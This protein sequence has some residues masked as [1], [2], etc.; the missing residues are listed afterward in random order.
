MNRIHGG[1]ACLALVAGIVAGCRQTGDDAPVARPSVEFV[2]GSLDFFPAALQVSPFT[3]YYKE[4]FRRMSEPSMYGARIP[5]GM[6]VIRLLW[7]R[8][9]DP[10]VVI[11]IA[12]TAE[13]CTIGTTIDG[14]GVDE[15]GVPDLQG[16]MPGVAK[17]YGPLLR[18]DSSELDLERCGRVHANAIAARL[19]S[20]SMTDTLFA[21]DGGD[22]VFELADSSGYYVAK[23]TDTQRAPEFW[24]VAARFIE[25]ANVN[26]EQ[27]KNGVW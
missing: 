9:F 23:R 8:S 12:M 6:T 18:R 14:V 20:G 10:V 24:K 15:F 13:R 25:L 27:F 11:R 16:G 7:F 17:R 5:A 21:N 1:A 3:G 19:W 22:I 2:G 26:P 4:V